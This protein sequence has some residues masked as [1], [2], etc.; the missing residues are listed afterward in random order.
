MGP[1]GE[2]GSGPVAVELTTMQ[3]R[4]LRGECAD[5]LDRPALQGSSEPFRADALER[6]RATGAAPIRTAARGMGAPPGQQRSPHR[7]APICVGGYLKNFPAAEPSSPPTWKQSHHV[8]CPP[9]RRPWARKPTFTAPVGCPSVP[10]VEHGEDDR[11]IQ[12]RAESPGY[13]A[14]RCRSSCNPRAAQ[15]GDGR[16]SACPATA[17]CVRIGPAAQICSPRH[18]RYGP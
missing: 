15:G 4:A 16:I 6:P 3:G 18:E 10:W 12:R 11:M 2:R 7:P 17:P 8:G 14:V 13:V 9:V 5:I 1:L